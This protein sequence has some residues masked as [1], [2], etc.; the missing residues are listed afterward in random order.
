MSRLFAFITAAALAA[1]VLLSGAHAQ[2]A[3][4][5]DLKPCVTVSMLMERHEQA[6]PNMRSANILFVGEDAAH[7]VRALNAWPPKTE[8]SG[9]E[10]VIFGFHG[11]PNS[12]VYVLTDGVACEPEIPVQNI[13]A[14]QLIWSTN[15]AQSE[16]KSP[17]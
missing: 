2:T 10:V 15:M 11:A 17:P 3:K 9:N 8:Y 6:V 13:I 12:L 1:T 4:P 5:D 16:R 7:F 14:N